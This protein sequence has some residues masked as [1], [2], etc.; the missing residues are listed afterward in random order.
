MSISARR[1]LMEIELTKIRDMATQ[2]DGDHLVY[3]V[4]MAISEVATRL[5][6]LNDNKEKYSKPVV[7]SR[8][9]KTR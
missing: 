2:I 9:R 8:P 3:F 1:K 7:I 5:D 6:Y 4:D